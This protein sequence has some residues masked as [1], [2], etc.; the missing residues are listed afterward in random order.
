MNT[1]Q[2]CDKK[3]D[4]RLARGLCTACYARLYRSTLQTEQSKK[5]AYEYR[6][7]YREHN[8][9]K[10]ADYRKKNRQKARAYSRARKVSMGLRKSR[11]RSAAYKLK[12]LETYQRVNVYKLEKGCVDCGYKDNPVALDFDHLPEFEKKHNVSNLARS[13]AAPETLWAEI[14]KCV[15]RC[16]N[17]HRIITVGR[18]LALKAELVLQ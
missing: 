11:P 2:E 7:Q 9:D 8:K 16:A 12:V 10:I 13:N 4:K 3:T 15:V 17:C 5:D 1:C 14:A 6:K 18:H